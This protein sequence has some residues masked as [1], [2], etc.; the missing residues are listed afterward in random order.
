[1]ERESFENNLVAPQNFQAAGFSSGTP[2]EANPFLQEAPQSF[3][4]EAALPP[5]MLPL[6]VAEDVRAGGGADD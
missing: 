5:S 1:M 2:L 3:E 6:E 4:A